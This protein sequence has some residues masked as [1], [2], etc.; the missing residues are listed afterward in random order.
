MRKTDSIHRRHHHSEG[1]VYRSACLNSSTVAV[2]K[3]ISRR[4]WCIEFLLPHMF[5]APGVLQQE[6]YYTKI[7]YSIVYYTII[8][9]C[10]TILYI[11][12]FVH[13][14]ADPRGPS[15][16]RRRPPRRP[17]TSRAP[18]ARP[19]ANL[20]YVC[21]YI[22]IYI[23]ICTE[24]EREIHMYIEREMY[25]YN[26]YIYIYIEREREIYRYVML[27]QCSITC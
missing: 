17:M 7:Y 5:A 12:P 8:I 20:Y 15:A 1:V 22:Y 27:L 3:I 11:C 2:S 21:V 4:W 16:R 19:F 26:M 25:V 10:Y 24:R 9:I 18:P 13:L 14:S 23:Y 6:L